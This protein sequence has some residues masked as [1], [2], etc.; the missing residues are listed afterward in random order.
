MK[1]ISSVRG[2][3]LCRVPLQ[4]YP[5]E[6][7]V[8]RWPTQAPAAAWLVLGVG[9][10]LEIDSEA[11]RQYSESRMV[12]CSINIV[13]QPW[14]LRPL[15]RLKVATLKPGGLHRHQKERRLPETGRGGHQCHSVLGSFSLAQLLRLAS[16]SSL[17]RQAGA[18]TPC[19]LQAA[20]KSPRPSRC[21][22]SSRAARRAAGL[23]PNSP[24]SQRRTAR[25][26]SG[27]SRYTAIRLLEAPPATATTGRGPPAKATGE[28]QPQAE[29]S[30]LGRF[31]I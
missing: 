9:V 21:L 6:W 7:R 24:D 2:L 18:R 31:I 23:P 30:A 4:R 13:S 20:P 28:L 8:L 3:G 22:A 17:F 19:E 1:R 26:S 5:A 16:S 15:R 12:G 27:V 10:D 25:R 11:M 14:K 29:R